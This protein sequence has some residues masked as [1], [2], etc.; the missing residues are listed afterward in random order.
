MRKVLAVILT[1]ITLYAIKETI[2]IFISND[3]EIVTHK[4]Q[5]IVIAFSITFPLIL[6]TLWLWRPK[7]KMNN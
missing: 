7:P 4:R 1:L 5:L 3:A 2:Y 6:L